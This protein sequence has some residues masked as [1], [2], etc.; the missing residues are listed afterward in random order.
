MQHKIQHKIILPFTFFVKTTFYDYAK[1]IDN[2]KSDELNID[3]LIHINNN[4]HDIFTYIGVLLDNFNNYDYVN[5]YMSPQYKNNDSMIN[6]NKTMLLCIEYFDELRNHICNTVEDWQTKMRDNS[7]I[8]IN[9]S[10]NNDENDKDFKMKLKYL[11]LSFLI[12]GHKTEWMHN[13]KL[14]FN[15]NETLTNKFTFV[16]FFNHVHIDTSLFIETYIINNILLCK[17][18]DEWEL[19]FFIDLFDTFVKFMTIYYILFPS[20][21]IHPISIIIDCVINSLHSLHSYN[22][23]KNIDDVEDKM[24]MLTC[25]NILNIFEF[26]HN[27]HNDNKNPINFYFDIL[28]WNDDEMTNTMKKI[29]DLLLINTR[30]H[31]FMKKYYYHLIDDNMIFAIN[32]YPIIN[33]SIDNYI[34]NSTISFL[35]SCY[36]VTLNIKHSYMFVE[37][38]K[39]LYNCDSITDVNIWFNFM[40]SNVEYIHDDNETQGEDKNNI[41]NIIASKVCDNYCNHI[42]EQKINSNFMFMNVFNKIKYDMKKIDDVSAI[43]KGL[44]FN[45]KKNKIH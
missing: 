22:D 37:M 11:C 27:S 2:N 13:K 16:R 38:I 41:I 28:L 4:N 31:K 7:I 36:A 39:I 17:I 8:S 1:H 3:V 23:K 42:N 10:A 44:T 6:F 29:R 19:N 34:D 26:F 35:F 30:L 5:N 15:A 21:V 25:K 12:Y 40:V 43:K 24:I 20:N 18:N 33:N 32:I 45:N 9:F 14:S